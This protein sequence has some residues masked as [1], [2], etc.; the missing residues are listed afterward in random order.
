M[1]KDCNSKQIK[2]RSKKE[3]ISIILMVATIQENNK[4]VGI[5]LIQYDNWKTKMIRDVPLSN[6]I[7]VIGSGAVKIENV[8]VQN[9]TLVGLNGSIERY[10]VISTDGKAIKGT[11]LVILNRIGDAGFTIGDYKGE[12]RKV[13]SQ[14][15][16]AYADKFSIANGKV[17]RND[18]ASYIS[19]I[20]GE[21]MVI[22]VAKSKASDTNSSYIR[23]GITTDGKNTNIGRATKEDVQQ[24][25]RDS[26]VF[27]SM[28]PEQKKVIQEYYVWHTVDVYRTMAHSL[29][30]DVSEDKLINLTQL[31]GEKNWEYAGFIDLGF[32]GAGKCALGHPIRY[33]HRAI[34][35]GDDL[36]KPSIQIIFGE[37]CSADF[38]RISPENMKKLIKIRTQM[39]AEIAIMADITANHTENEAWESLTL[40]LEVI[41]KL[42]S[43]K[44]VYDVFG[45]K[46]GSTL[47]AFLHAKM[48]FPESL[49]KLARTKAIENGCKEFWKKVFPEYSSIINEVYSRKV[50]IYGGSVLDVTQLY[51]DFTASNR[52]DGCY[53]YDPIKGVCKAEGGFN[54]KTRT[55]RRY[56]LDRIRRATLCNKFTLDECKWLFTAIAELMKGKQEIENTFGSEYTL[57]DIKN[58]I[59][60]YKREQL[61]A[62]SLD[63]K[64]QRT[65]STLLSAIVIDSN[66]LYGFKKVLCSDMWFR[67]GIKEAADYY[68]IVMSEDFKKAI[69]IIKEYNK[70][71]EEEERLEKEKAEER[72][73]REKEE[74]DRRKAEAERKAREAEERRKRQLEEKQKQKDSTK[75]EFSSLSS[76]FGKDTDDSSDVDSNIEDTEDKTKDKKYTDNLELVKHLIKTSD[77]EGDVQGVR[78][79]K[80]ILSSGKK[81]KELSPKQR[82]V[83]QNTIKSFGE[84][85]VN[86][87]KAEVNNEYKLSEHPE[88]EANVDKL[89]SIELT[90]DGDKIFETDKIVF[91]I[92]RSIKSR[93]KASDRQLK[94]INEAIEL[95]K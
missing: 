27:K 23:T 53:A 19:A 35:E 10:A 12:T 84:T 76:T 94:H 72:I 86:G 9:G 26:D 1:C 37:T 31:K 29:R 52:L 62:V 6:A 30:L 64:T 54:K 56:L 87:G 90:P 58:I 22:E 61:D 46:I 45:E 14:D 93:G 36:F 95:L 25:M 75:E 42:G 51:L 55:E 18:N 82:Y 57:N 28:T 15:L 85:P 59:N 80:S 4:M 21:Y 2:H 3:D 44:N 73:K 60:R 66:I 78:I 16:V 65:F 33:A 81:W 7:S 43:Q 74:H 48:P 71:K 41:R 70:D 89:I 39:S 17:V 77:K 88:I 47:L 69:L 83:V 49:V 38:F 32:Q 91:S 50:S 40:L 13:R 24:E 20:N 92:A 67:G 5:R 68:S 79:C 11:P 8:S 34:P 63:E